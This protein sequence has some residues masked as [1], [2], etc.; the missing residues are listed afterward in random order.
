MDQVVCALV[1]RQKK[2]SIEFLSPNKIN[3]MFCCS[4]KILGQKYGF[5]I[6]KMWI[7]KIII[8]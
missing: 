7:I 8:K 1:M 2:K 5:I 6:G 3:N 4:S